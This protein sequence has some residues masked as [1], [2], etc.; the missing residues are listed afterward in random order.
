[1]KY[2]SYVYVATSDAE[3]AAAAQRQATVVD[4]DFETGGNTT[5]IDVDYSKEMKLAQD[6]SRRTS[7][8]HRKREDA[9]ADAFESRYGVLHLR[10]RLVGVHGSHIPSNMYVVTREPS[11][12]NYLS[13]DET[14]GPAQSVLIDSKN[15]HTAMMSMHPALDIAWTK[16]EK[17]RHDETEA[18]FSAKPPA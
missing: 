5:T 2:T 7:K 8:S 4:G 1:M 9:V 15:K 17:R 10:R 3:R 12:L 13:F 18:L 11:K 14:N 6:V 16:D